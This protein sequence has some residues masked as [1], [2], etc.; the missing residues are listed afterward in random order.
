MTVVAGGTGGN[1]WYVRPDGGTPY[2]NSTDTP[3]GQCNGLANAAY[4][5][6]GVNQACA[7]G[8]FE[9]L[10]FD[11]VTHKIQWVINGGD[12]V[13]VYPKAA[14]YDTANIDASAGTP[15]NCSTTEYCDLPSIPSGTASRPTRILGSNYTSCNGSYGPN[16]A[17]TTL[18][19]G[20]GREMMQANLSQFID[21]ECFEMADSSAS[22]NFN[23]GIWQSALTS[24]A[25]FKNLFIHNATGSGIFGASGLGM[26]Y[27]HTHIRAAENTGFQM[28]DAPY[29]IGNISVSGGLTLTNSNIEFTGCR[30]IYGSTAQYPFVA[31]GCVD[32]NSGHNG[33]GIGTGAMTGA[34]YY[35]NDIFRYNFQDGLDNL[36]AGAQS[37]TV[38]NSQSYGNDGQPY[39]IGDVD[40]GVFQNNLA[41]GNCNR[42]FEPFNGVVIAATSAVPCRAGGGSANFDWSGTGS[43]T[44]QYNTFI[45]V[46][47]PMF[48]EFCET[49]WP[50]CSGAQTTL[51]NNIFAGYTDSDSVYRSGAQAPALYV[52]TSGLP[53]TNGWVT[54]SNNDF[55]N[56]V[57]Y[58]PT[59]A[60]EL[61]VDP[62]FIGEPPFLTE[63]TDST[64]SVLDNYNHMPSSNSTILGA[65]MY[66]SDLTT[67]ANGVV[68]PNPPAMGAL[69][70]NTGTT[71]L[72][73]QVVLTAAPTPVTAG[74][75]VTLSASVASAT[76]TSG[77]APT[78]TVTFYSN[79][80]SL[81]DG[82][83]S[84]AGVATLTTSLTAAGVDPL[85]ATYLGDTNYASGTSP[86][87]SL[88]VNASPGAATTTVLSV[89]SA[90]ITAGDSITLTAT[91][92]AGSESKPSGTVSFLSNGVLLGTAPLNNAGVAALTTSSLA[93]GS[94]S[95]TAQYGGNTGFNASSS[96][97]SSVT[98]NS[99]SAAA[100][101]TVLSV[102]S[103]SITAGD[104]ITLT[105]TVTAGAGSKP[106]GTV[107]FLSN[108]VLLGTAP[109]N[110]AGV[111][112]LTT[113]SLAAGSYSVTAKYGG[114]TSFNASTSSPS[115]VTVNSPSAAATTTVLSVSSASI[116]AGDSIT[117]TATVTAGSES[118]PSG[119][120]SF[121]SNGVLLGTAPL[122]SAGVATLTTSSLA[123][124][125][126]SIT[127]KYGSNTSFN[128]STSSPLSVT[129][130][131]TPAIV[132]TTLLSVSSASIT[133]GQTITLKAT[134]ATGTGGSPSG[135]VS[136]F[137]NGVLLGTAPLNNAGVAMLTTAPLAAGSYSITA[138]YGG[139]TS[140]NA[141]TSSPLGETVTAGIAPGITVVASTPTL[142]IG[143]GS[144]TSDTEILTLNAVG[145]YSGTIQMSCANL[146]TGSTCSFQPPT[147]TVN[148][149]T[150][151]VTVAMTIL[152]SGT[153]TT[154]SLG[155]QHVVMR[156]STLASI[157]W[158]PGLFAAAL[159]GK[160]R[161][162]LLQS[163]LL[164]LILLLGVVS[165][166]LAGCGSSTFTAITPAAQ[167]TTF[168]VMAIGTGNVSQT[169][170]LNV[171]T[172]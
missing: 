107:S 167:T 69:Q 122:N 155:M 168:Q 99:P 121:L 102:S 3:A 20:N 6:T 126:Y 103:A 140:Y 12:T 39:K 125:S 100:T 26:V 98:V 141:S 67:D 119:T 77:A 24:Y 32:Q 152:N 44:Y 134:V 65:G 137:G 93:A 170:D 11:Q 62:L 90:S 114:N 130:N 82:V 41:I 25:T 136:F 148:A 154:A 85:T 38:I 144:S 163:R 87:L 52:A 81:G 36:H 61:Q 22:T 95:V 27:D 162:L 138:R 151:P 47:N 74:Q 10:Y 147:V 133:S 97:P 68:R 110:N 153:S 160:K 37:E 28:D 135:T 19:L 79:G 166:G 4:P 15:T 16:P 34:W 17:M 86:T 40:T 7:F 53:G 101:T 172:P 115:S 9:D 29:G 108:G 43:Y 129:A 23:I 113:S 14:G 171:T 164:L 70:S 105:A 75:P 117:L 156:D 165:G 84:N 142:T 89:S 57:S 118:K 124:G 73:S 96:S 76:S 49:T 35:D 94:Y 13:M 63:L 45:G 88:T 157:F 8:D 132:T 55:S 127:A 5:G 71:L 33:D 106:S 161:K 31:N 111:A 146:P 131:P 78:G 50:N 159:V 116:T 120:V 21:V 123:A 104:S 91:V 46:G 56:V 109:L 54:R 149:S 158:I 64:E 139:N 145:G 1:T 66:I 150:S 169:I 30:E 48:G 42:A 72:A 83:V 60:G 112:A 92:T 18:L 2:T 80:T 143:S 59:S 128:A 58:T 51:E